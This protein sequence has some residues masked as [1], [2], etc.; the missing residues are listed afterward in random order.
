MPH[1]VVSKRLVLSS[2]VELSGKKKIKKNERVTR[3]PHPPAGG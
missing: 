2:Y 3:G 1:I